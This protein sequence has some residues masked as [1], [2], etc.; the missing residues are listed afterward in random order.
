MSQAFTYDDLNRLTQAVGSAYGTQSFSYDSIGNMT[1]KAGR[2]MSYGEGAPGPHAATTLS[3]NGT[4]YPT[5]GRDYQGSCALTYDTND[6]MTTRGQDALAYD[7]ENRLKE[8]KLRE[9]TTG[10]Q[11]YTD[12][13]PESVQ[14]TRRVPGYLGYCFYPA[15]V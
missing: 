15:I 2:T 14:P 8:M 10:T 12:L 13:P 11:S 1:S 3:W 5:F 7:S 6:N 4:N 9:G